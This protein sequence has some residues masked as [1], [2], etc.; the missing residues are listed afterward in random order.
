MVETSI[1]TTKGQLVIPARIRRRLGIK[2]GTRV[3]LIEEGEKIVLRPLTPDYFR[4]AAGMLGTG[5]KVLKAFLEDKKR[6]R[7]L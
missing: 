2:R 4:K 3:C 6:E 5:G 1:V 7:E